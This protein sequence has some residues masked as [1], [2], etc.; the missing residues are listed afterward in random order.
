VSTGIVLYGPPAAGK[1]TV[2]RALRALDPRYQLFSRLKAGP[3][4]TTGYRMT[5]TAAI[6]ALHAQGEVIWESQRYGAT[7][8]IDRSGLRACLADHVSVLHVGQVDAVRA[9]LASDSVVMWL[10]A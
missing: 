10:V 3:G 6:D 7:Y 1:D 8:V 4:R 2:T 5:T 9:V